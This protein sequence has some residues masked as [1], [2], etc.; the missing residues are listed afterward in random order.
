MVW[1]FEAAVDR[2]S[3]RMLADALSLPR[4]IAEVLVARGYA[5]VEEAD[6]FLKPRLTELRPPE[7]LPDIAP[8]AARIWRAIDAKERVAVFG[9][10]DVDGVTSTALMVQVL[11]H[12]GADVVPF[13][14]HRLEEGYGLSSVAL[15][16]CLDDHGP[17]LI[18][19]VDCGTGSVAAVQEAQSRGVDVIITDH[20][21]LG[22][23]LP[24]AVAVVNPQRGADA[25]LKRLAGV[26]VAFKLCHAILKQ[27]REAK[28]EEASLDLRPLLDLVALGT[29]AD[30]VPLVGENRILSAHGLSRLR[31]T[32]S[33]GLN[34]LMSVAGIKRDEVHAY[35]VGFQIGPRLNAA[36]RLG[37]AEAALNLLLSLE[38]QPAREL[39]EFLNAANRE[40]QDAEKEILNAALDDLQARFDP[41]RDFGL[42]VAGEDWNPGVIGIVASRLV[43]HFSRPV[44]V[45]AKDE[46]GGRG[47]C[48]SIGEF[49]IVAGLRACAK[50]LSKF[51]GHAMAAGLELK[52]GQLEPFA[53]AFNRVAAAALGHR[54]L[55]PSLR[56]DGVV[57][58]DEVDAAFFAAQESM[59]PFGMGN[60]TPV[61]AALGVRVVGPPR[62]LK[63][64]HLKLVVSS[65]AQQFAAMG[66][67]MG[68]REV[69]DGPIDI[70]FQIKENRYGGRV[71]LDLILQD[72]R[73]AEK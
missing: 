64:K 38:E 9:D 55:R 63:D 28:R 15:Q 29:I 54:D 4:P 2:A 67:D 49:D 53:E 44:I 3:A 35:H 26:G 71:S 23:Q 30:V 20:H 22:E 73:P 61:W 51:G 68:G 58:L 10:Y 48:R 17:T 70:A 59:R 69:P 56:I 11:R 1:R 21:Q 12:L 25:D 13:L 43:Q 52:P 16:R 19:T 33:A 31:K 57:S 34:E 46:D 39:A 5:S 27:G 65:G 14:P 36:G 6:R 37:G 60:P 42:V 24:E 50:H 41:E 72:F 7:H 62:I 47:S 8:A 40:R 45:I 32:T 66:W 18:I